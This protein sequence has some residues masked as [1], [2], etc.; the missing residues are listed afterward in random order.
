[1]MAREGAGFRKKAAFMRALNNEGISV[2]R[3]TFDGY[4]SGEKDKDIPG[5]YIAAVA[6]LTGKDPAWLLSGTASPA[7]AKLEKIREI[8][9]QPIKAEPE[10]PAWD[11]PGVALAA[12]RLLR[13]K[14]RGRGSGGA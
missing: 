11:A 1:M 7:H 3:K 12:E 8:L 2:S 14:K 5:I 6:R 4:E 10:D 13:R 9:D